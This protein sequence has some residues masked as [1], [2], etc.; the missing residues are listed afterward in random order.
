[1]C[2]LRSASEANEST[3][4]IKQQVSLIQG[5]YVPVEVRFRG[6]WIIKTTNQQATI[7][8]QLSAFLSIV[9]IFV[10]EFIRVFARKTS[11]SEALHIVSTNFGQS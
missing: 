8:D 4:T 10:T 3:K 9:S 2:Q 1:M 11:R 6:E 5:N 7:Y